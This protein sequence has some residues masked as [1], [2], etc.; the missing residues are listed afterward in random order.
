[1]LAYVATTR[2]VTVTVRVVYLDKHSDAVRHRFA[3][4]CH[5]HLANEGMGEVQILERCWRVHQANGAVHEIA[6]PVV[7]LSNPPFVRPGAAFEHAS[8]CTIETF[9]G[10]V[11]GHYLLQNTYGDRFRATLPRLPLHAA[12]N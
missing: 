3:F 8:Q 5:A 6:E 9:D 7:K 11:E 2:G 4:D 12:A 1:M 10:Y